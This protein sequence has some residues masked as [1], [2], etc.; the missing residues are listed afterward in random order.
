MKG[1][2]TILPPQDRCQVTNTHF[3]WNLYIQGIRNGFSRNKVVQLDRNGLMGIRN[4]KKKNQPLVVDV[5]AQKL[6]L[7][8]GEE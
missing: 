7:D 1:S 6:E 3:C 2:I 5:L 8:Q 4:L